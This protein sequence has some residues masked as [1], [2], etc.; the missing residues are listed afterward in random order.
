MDENQ[1]QEFKNKT[2]EFAL[3]ASIPICYYPF[4]TKTYQMS[5]YQLSEFLQK[6]YK[7]TFSYIQIALEIF[8]SFSDFV[9]FKISFQSSRNQYLCIFYHSSIFI[10]L[11]YGFA[12]DIENPTIS[13]VVDIFNKTMLFGAQFITYKLFQSYTSNQPDFQS[14]FQ[15]GKHLQSQIQ[16]VFVCP[17]ALGLCLLNFHQLCKF[18][19]LVPQEAQ[20][21]E[22]DNAILINYQF[23]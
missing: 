9:L 15:F 22:F 11:L 8:L 18:T 20:N 17:V 14:N 2:L 12:R 21:G 13:P 16:Q 10:Y 1:L 23:Q 5:L 6:S 3:I 7:T 19:N 4:I